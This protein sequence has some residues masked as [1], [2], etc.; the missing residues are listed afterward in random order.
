MKFPFAQSLALGLLGSCW[1]HAGTRESANGH[2][3]LDVEARDASPESLSAEDINA[4]ILE[5]MNLLNTRSTL[6]GRDVNLPDGDSDSAIDK[7]TLQ[8]KGQAIG[9]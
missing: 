3:I 1:A 8:A 2:H 9:M 5:N 4:A 7:N 6:A